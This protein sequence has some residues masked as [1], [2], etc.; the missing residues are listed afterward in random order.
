MRFG[1]VFETKN[2]PIFLSILT[3][4]IAIAKKIVMIKLINSIC[5]SKH[6]SLLGIVLI[7][8]IC[9]NETVV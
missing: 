9:L 6:K 7:T 5:L 2:M 8:F 3:G 4:I 1:L